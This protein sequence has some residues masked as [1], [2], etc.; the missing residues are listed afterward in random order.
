MAWQISRALFHSQPL[1]SLSLSFS[2]EKFQTP[3][4]ETKRS[5]CADYFLFLEKKKKNCMCQSHS[6]KFAL[7]I[8]YQKLLDRLSYRVMRI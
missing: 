8:D 5:S 6:K 4:H 3:L 2:K 1:K 7:H